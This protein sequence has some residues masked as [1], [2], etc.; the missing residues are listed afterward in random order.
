MAKRCSNFP[1]YKLYQYIYD[2]LLKKY[3]LRYR[4]IGIR[5]LPDLIKLERTFSPKIKSDF[6]LRGESE[7]LK[8]FTGLHPINENVFAGDHISDTASG[9]RI[10]S[11]LIAVFS[12]DKEMLNIYYFRGIFKFPA[13]RIS[14]VKS[15]LNHIGNNQTY[16]HLT[17]HNHE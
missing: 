15:F 3:A 8:L 1:S 4:D 5:F 9:N 14:F 16:K 11:M 6:V 17:P 13:A 12:N 2:P 10:K 7:G